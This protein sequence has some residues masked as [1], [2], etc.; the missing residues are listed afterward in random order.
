MNAVACA[1]VCRPKMPRFAT[2]NVSPRPPGEGP[3]VRASDHTA[4]SGTLNDTD[5]ASAIKKALPITDRGNRWGDE[6][7]FSIPAELKE[8]D[9]AQA[10]VDL[11]ALAYW[12]PGKAFCIFF[13]STPASLGDEPRAASAVNIFGHLEGNI[14]NCRKIAGAAAIRI[15]AA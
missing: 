14:D 8:A 1:T 7:Y 11:G 12:P 2:V 6:F 13:G 9:G 15:S 4:A 5:T 3:G 10:E